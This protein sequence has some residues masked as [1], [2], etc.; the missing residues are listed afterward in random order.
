[1]MQEKISFELNELEVKYVQ[2]QQK[3]IAY[4]QR[5]LE[6]ATDLSIKK[7]ESIDDLYGGAY[8]DSDG[9][10]KVYIKDMKS[11][12]VKKINAVS[13]EIEV[14]L[15]EYTLKELTEIK[16]EIDNFQRNRSDKFGETFHAW[17]L[18]DS[19]NRIIVA[20]DEL[21]DE[22]IKIFKNIVIDS[23][24]IVFTQAK[25]KAQN[26]ATLLK[27]GG[28]ITGENGSNY[29]IGYAVELNGGKGILT[30]AHGSTR[31]VQAGQKF[32]YGSN[33]IGRCLKTELGGSL[34]VSFV[35]VT[36]R[37]FFISNTIEIIQRELSTEIRYPSAGTIVF[38]AGATTGV[39]S[40]T[41]LSTNYSGMIDGEIFSNLTT[42]NY[43][44]AAG[45]S[46][47]VVFYVP[48]DGIRYTVGIH[49]G[50]VD[51]DAPDVKSFVKAGEI[52]RLWGVERV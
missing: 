48:S 18:D 1:M 40:G 22:K 49:K 19:A 27:P 5:I 17:W 39:T 6:E 14:C 51:Y 37:N 45:D 7:N 23:N 20:F 10:L 47:G 42:T 13:S 25:G 28:K 9:K 52:R 3:S 15:G 35:S 38:K 41:I 50:G 2:K 16:N 33:E 30:S 8:I 26:E 46:G 31:K 24:A 4:Y 36:N 44:S 21:T 43:N 12:F 32:F 34:D 29:S 11:D